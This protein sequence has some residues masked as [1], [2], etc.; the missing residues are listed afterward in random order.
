MPFTFFMN[1]KI[2]R[3]DTTI[4]F[5]EG[6]PFCSF[7]PVPRGVVDASAPVL[8]NLGD[9][10]ELEKA[11]WTART[12]RNIAS[13]S[14]DDKGRCQ[15]WYARGLTPGDSESVRETPPRPSNPRKFS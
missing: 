12:E 6:E 14:N 7:F 1:W 5:R 8:K 3:P 15:N 9:D 13:S 10:P 11:Y 2:T 4:V